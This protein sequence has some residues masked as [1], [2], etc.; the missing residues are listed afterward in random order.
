MIRQILS[1]ETM[2]R[3]GYIT[4]NDG[5]NWD[6][7]RKNPVLMLEHEDDKQPIGR[8]DNI[9]FE[10]NAWYGDLVFADTEEGREKEKLYNEGFY[11]AVS[12]SGLATKVKREGVVYAVQFDVWEVSL[13]AVPANPN[14]IAQRTS[15]KSTLSVS[16]NDVDDKLIEPDS[17]SAYQISTINKFKENMEANNKPETEVKEEALK[18]PESVEAA[19]E[20]PSAEHKGFMSRVLSSLSA[21]TSMLN[22]RKE[23]AQAQPEAESLKAP[24]AAEAPE[25]EKTETE[26]EAQKAPE[27]K[28]ELSAKPEPKIFNIHEKTPKIKMTA[29]KSVNDYLR[30][31][32]GQYK[33]RQIQKLSAVP[34]K[35]LRRPE[36]ATPVEFVREY[37]ALMANDPGFMSFMGN[38]TFQNAD[39]PKEVFSKTLDKL[40]IGENSIDFLETSPDLAKITWLSLFYRV[41]LPE[42][43]WADRCMRV[44][45]DSHAG[46][47][48]INSAMNPKVYVGSRAPLNAKTSYYEDIPV[49]LAEKVFSMEPIGWQPAT[50]DVLA[51]NNRATGQSE[52]MRVVVNKIHNYWLQMF[53]EA[54]SVKVPMS[55]PD[56]FAVDASTF[57]INDAATGTLLEFA[58]KNITQMQKGFINQNYTMD[59]NEAV[60]VMAAA[61]F[62]QL[63][64]DPLITSI[65][66]KQTGRVGPM[67]VQYSGFEAM[68][69]STVAA[70]DTASSK[71]VDAELYCDGKVNADGTIPSYTPP[72]LT[73]TAYDI[74]LGFIPGEAIIAQGNT[75]VH[76]VQ[77]PN[78]YSWVMSM[79]IRS[80]AGAA[81]KGGLGIGIIIPAVSA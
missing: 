19:P 50:T 31:D 65:L 77:N 6:E 21:I 56:T 66:S 36:N 28:E 52:A 39:G 73:A 29:F 76:M 75:N 24:E 5:V 17:L 64:N 15:D 53:A 1:D 26:Q 2:N 51:Y 16:F 79:D 41:L 81:R 44:S 58:L 3:K 35:E 8:I 42:N 4:L 63:Q 59:Y 25:T 80:G 37:S 54:A 12:I 68:P 74:A 57:P 13:V 18:A 69:R 78:D 70:Y 55:G 61:Y 43:S 62:E 10:D 20:E 40:N 9:R 72:V 11:N 34:S 33:F 7:Y 23:E 46:V 27:G 14:A 22:D 49:A 38:V 45:G 47:I 71:V 48:W 67:T 32:E 60:M 30:S